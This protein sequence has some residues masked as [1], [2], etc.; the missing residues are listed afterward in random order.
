MDGAG[1]EGDKEAS[2]SQVSVSRVPVVASAKG[3]MFIRKA[4][5]L[6]P[7]TALLDPCQHIYQSPRIP[8]QGRDH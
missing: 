6:T 2:K 1:K 8:C 7:V 5:L 4:D 3:G